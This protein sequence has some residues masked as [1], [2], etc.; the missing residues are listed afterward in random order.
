MP[1][2]R[3]HCASAVAHVRHEPRNPTAHRHAEECG[4]PAGP[5]DQAQNT[6]ICLPHSAAPGGTDLRQIGGSACFPT[7]GF[8]SLCDQLA[9]DARLMTGSCQQRAG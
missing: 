6:R 8:A 4:Q 1:A 9:N 2:T 3:S 5:T 7:G